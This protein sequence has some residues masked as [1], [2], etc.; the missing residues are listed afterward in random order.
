MYTR[1]RAE[2]IGELV[3]HNGQT[4]TSKSQAIAVGIEQECRNLGLDA[5]DSALQKGFA[6]QWE[7]AFIA[8]AHATGEAASKDDSNNRFSSF[9]G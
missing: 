5:V 9:H 1:E 3:R 6:S 2:V 8:A 4:G 7:K